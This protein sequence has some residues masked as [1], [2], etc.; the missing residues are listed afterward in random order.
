ML[1]HGALPYLI[2]WKPFEPARSLLKKYYHDLDNPNCYKM[3]DYVTTT[4]IAQENINTVN[5]DSNIKSCISS[6]LL[7]SNPESYVKN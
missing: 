6:M 2:Y 5:L 7:I 1:N 3:T 4:S